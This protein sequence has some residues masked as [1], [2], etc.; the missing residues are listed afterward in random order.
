MLVW[1]ARYCRVSS[2]LLKLSLSV[3]EYTTM[4]TWG[5]YVVRMFSACK[6]CVTMF[7]YYMNKITDTPRKKESLITK[8]RYVEIIR[9]RERLLCQV[10]I[11][12]SGSLQATNIA[13][14]N[15]SYKH[16]QT[17]KKFMPI[18]THVMK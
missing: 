18:E 4:Q 5:S 12:I 11:Q 17:H 14:L 10:N 6:Q 7:K 1:E 8:F 16:H 15:L 2:A 3:M 9:E 13:G